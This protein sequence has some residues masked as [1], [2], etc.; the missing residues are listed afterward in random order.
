MFKKNENEETKVVPN[1]HDSTKASASKQEEQKL[2]LRK[3]MKGCQALV[4]F[5]V[6]MDLISPSITVQGIVYAAASTMI[7]LQETNGLRLINVMNIKKKPVVDGKQKIL[8]LRKISVVDQATQ[9][10]L[11]KRHHENRL[12]RI[13]M[14][15]NRNARASPWAQKI[16]DDLQKT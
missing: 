7:V 10:A 6:T 4:G 11:S 15:G 12:K 16:F 3:R 14:L 1:K 8:D 13:K 9:D 2:S 5:H